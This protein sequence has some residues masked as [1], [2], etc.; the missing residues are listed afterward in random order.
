MAKHYTPR[1]I[2]RLVPTELWRRFFETFDQPIDVDW[3]AAEAD[4]ELI[5]QAWLAWTPGERERCE[6]YWRQ[7]HDLGTPS[8][9]RILIEE[10]RIE[11]FEAMR[12]ETSY[13]PAAMAVWYFLEARQAFERASLFQHAESLAERY[14]HRTPGMTKGVPDSCPQALKKLGCRIGTYLQDEQGRGHR[15]TVEYYRRGESDHYFFCYPDDYTEV[16]VGHDDGGRL[17][18]TP[19]R[20]TFEVIAV[21]ESDAGELHV[22]APMTRPIREGL[23]DLFA[24][25]VLLQDVPEVNL[26]RPPYELDGLFDPDFPLPFDPDS[27]IR[28]VSLRRMRVSFSRADRRLIFEVTPDGLLADLRPFLTEVLPAA[29][30]PRA[31]L[32]ITDAVFAVTYR[33]SDRLRDK[34]F[35]FKVAYPDTCSLK[36][37]PDDQ[38]RLGEACLRRWGIARD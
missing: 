38:R 30:Y 32:H 24:E 20:R 15:C 27:G 9:L 13:G 25:T 35:Q 22:Y 11:G 33:P 36:S 12:P 3:D 17:R 14:W 28:K 10:A 16:E 18:R 8:G 19:V 4:V 21:F 26:R 29:T 34:T 37:K 1:G 31:N 2:L 23:T 5:Y 6:S 7:F